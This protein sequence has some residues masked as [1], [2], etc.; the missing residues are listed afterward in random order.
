MFCCL[1]GRI[2]V[3]LLAH[4]WE[5]GTVLTFI[6][7]ILSIISLAPASTTLMHVQ[8]IILKIIFSGKL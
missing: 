2:K 7:Q 3:V 8:K 1:F 5:L 4:C 6:K